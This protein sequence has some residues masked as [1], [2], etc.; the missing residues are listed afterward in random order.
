MED[1]GRSKLEAWESK[2][3]G[4]LP[5]D[6]LLPGRD[7]DGVCHAMRGRGTLTLATVVSTQHHRNFWL[8]T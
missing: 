5:N 2:L 8:N 7:V 6:W 4:T 3:E 1:L